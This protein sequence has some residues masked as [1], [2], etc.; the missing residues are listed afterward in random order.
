[1]CTI[2]HF[3]RGLPCFEK[4]VRYRFDLRPFVLT[5]QRSNRDGGEG[6]E[7]VAVLRMLTNACSIRFQQTVQVL[8]KSREWKIR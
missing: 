5:V 6:V 7:T 1:M 4:T 2:S 3:E 8:D